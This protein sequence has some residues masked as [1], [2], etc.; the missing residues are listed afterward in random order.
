MLRQKSCAESHTFALRY[1]FLIA[2]NHAQT[3]THTHTYTHPSSQTHTC[4]Y[5]TRITNNR[6]VVPAKIIR[7]LI[8]GEEKKQFRLD[9]NSKTIHTEI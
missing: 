4:T 9:L 6:S 2:S 8:H 7:I 3:H 1:T 5:S